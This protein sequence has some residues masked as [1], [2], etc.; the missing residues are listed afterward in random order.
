MEEYPSNVPGKVLTFYAY[1]YHESDVEEQL[2]RDDSSA[3]RSLVKPPPRAPYDLKPSLF[4]KR[5]MNATVEQ[6]PFCIM[7]CGIAS[8]GSKLVNCSRCKTAH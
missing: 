7:C 1:A 6:K 8:S 5:W 2:E 4:A 3:R